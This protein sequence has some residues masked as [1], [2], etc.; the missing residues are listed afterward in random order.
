MGQYEWY[1]CKRA[2]TPELTRESIVEAEPVTHAVVDLGLAWAAG[3]CLCPTRWHPG[4]AKPIIRPPHIHLISTVHTHGSTCQHPSRHKILSTLKT[5]RF[6]FNADSSI[7]MS[8]GY[9]TFVRRIYQKRITCF[10]P[11]CSSSTRR[12]PASW[13]DSRRTP[14]RRCSCP[15]CR[16]QP[17]KWD[18]C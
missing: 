8:A 2:L 15:T 11:C 14:G 10:G 6:K 5:Y 3:G 18:M 17:R 4:S 1:I 7:C 9:P 13:P 12:R 16:S